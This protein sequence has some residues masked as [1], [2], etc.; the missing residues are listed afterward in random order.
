MRRLALVLAVAAAVA[1]V[2]A[3]AAA[4]DS[5]LRRAYQRAWP[6]LERVAERF[7]RAADR[8]SPVRRRGARRF[9]K[10]IASARRE[11]RVI[12]SA[13]ARETPSSRTGIQAKRAVVRTLAALDSAFVHLGRAVKLLARRPTPDRLRRAWQH[14]RRGEDLITSAERLEERTA[15][16]MRQ[17]PAAD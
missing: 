3:P 8:W 15:S 6:Q 13:L 10:A 2:P 9:A 14:A 11:G 7:N 16:L 12:R 1:L 17:L 5:S 4:D